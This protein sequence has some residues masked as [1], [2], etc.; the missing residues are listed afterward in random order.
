MRGA[1]IFSE[2][3]VEPRMLKHQDWIDNTLYPAVTGTFRKLVQI[4]ESVSL[5]AAAK[6]ASD[7]QLDDMRSHLV[8]LLD[9]LDEEQKRRSLGSI[10]LEASS[11]KANE[12]KTLDDCKDDDEK[13]FS[14]DE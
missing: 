2:L 1:T 14:M 5:G 11:G 7:E 3:V 4:V 10:Q 6:I 8:G 9:K 13:S 12:E